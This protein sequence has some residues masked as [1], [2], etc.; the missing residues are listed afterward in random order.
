[1]VTFN[2]I[3]RAFNNIA[4]A[5]K[6]IN[7]Y[8]IGDIWE[9]A[10]SG[11]IRYPMMWAKPENGSLETNV[12][13][14]EWTLIFMDLV[15]NGERNEN[16][17]ISDMEQVAL[18]VVALLGDSSYDFDF[19]YEGATLERFTER[20]ED[21]VAGVLARISIRVPYTAD[22][23]QV[24]QSGLTITN[25]SAACA[26]VTITDNGD[27]ISVASGG[28]YTCTTVAC[29]DATAVLINSSGTIISST[30]IAS[31][32]TANITAPDG[33]VI[34]NTQDGTQLGSKAVASNGN[35]VITLTDSAMYD[36]LPI[37]Y[38][39]PPPTGQTTSYA[40][41]D[42][43]YYWTNVWQPLFA[44]AIVGKRPQLSDFTTL[45][46]NN[47]FGN[48]SRFT[49]SLGGQVY[50]AGN[51]SLSNYVIDH[52]TGFGIYNVL[53]ESISFATAIS[54]AEAS[55][56]HG[57]TD[58]FIGNTN[59]I[60]SII[61]KHIV[62]PLNYSPFNNTGGGA[63]VTHL[64]TS[65]TCAGDTAFANVVTIEHTTPQNNGCVFPIVKT[66]AV[67]AMNYLMFR[68]HF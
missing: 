14:S 12:Y 51:G 64:W 63:S 42:D 37:A 48:T 24:P 52:Y 35:G 7:T 41:G 26:G 43:A 4:V 46:S 67:Q 32:A 20:F 11:D 65:S 15:D 55:S 62:L 59:H 44:T 34:V 13:V 39:W 66:S 18:D 60:I 54:N 29:S 61:N 9:I 31:G 1:M 22:R 50:G 8:G 68:K 2:Q 57:F 16:D 36:T 17:V 33:T 21:K 53:T 5:H 49:D 45:I 28:S 23:C 6:Q 19:N 27:V 40:T 56:Q 58:W 10:T 25:V 3:N 38:N 47:S 30:S